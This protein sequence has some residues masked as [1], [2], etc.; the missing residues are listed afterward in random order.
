MYITH[1]RNCSEGLADLNPMIDGVMVSDMIG[2]WTNLRVGGNML[3]SGGEMW[4]VM[5][6]HGPS[7]P[8]VSLQE[9]GVKSG[10]L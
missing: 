3:R 10:D 8:L 7:T 1:S 2:R 6:G 4:C 5:Y 9:S